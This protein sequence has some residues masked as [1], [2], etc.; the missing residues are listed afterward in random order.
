[1]N[2]V[3]LYPVSTPTQFFQTFGDF[4]S[5]NATGVITVFAFIVVLS[6][7]MGWFESST[8]RLRP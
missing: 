8:K 7:V 2:D 4:M 3:Q 5:S 6:F 1:M